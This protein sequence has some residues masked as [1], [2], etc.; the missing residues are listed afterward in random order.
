MGNSVTNR[1]QFTRPGG[2][3]TALSIYYYEIDKQCTQIV[4][5]AQLEQLK[6][7]CV[8][9]VGQSSPPNTLIVDGTATQSLWS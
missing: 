8:N 3:Y 6:A 2:H 5:L 9:Y 1:Q 7:H 4:A